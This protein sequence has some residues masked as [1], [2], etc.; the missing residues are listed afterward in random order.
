MEVIQVAQQVIMK[1]TDD[2]DGTEASGSVQFTLEGRSYEIDLSDE[3]AA[4]LRDVF[5]P[6]VA[7]A[8][9]AGGRGRQAEASP[10]PRS[11]SARSREETQEIR[12]WLK[13][14]GY[15]VSDRGRISAEFMQAWETKIP[16]G[17]EG[18]DQPQNN[19]AS[20]NGHA[21]TFQPA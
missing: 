19:D 7:V 15:Q 1:Y 6:Y 17:T 21:V 20:S 2:L 12:N 18:N 5:A 13:A 14:N 10:R 8:R 11:R 9:R 4:K 3:N 16:A